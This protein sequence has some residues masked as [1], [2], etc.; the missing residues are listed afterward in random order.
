[1]IANMV[2][3]Q[4][5]FENKR[6]LATG[7]AL[8]GLSI[9]QLAVAPYLNTLINAYRLNGALLLHGAITLNG[10]GLSMLLRP[11][12]FASPSTETNSRT[13]YCGRLYH[14]CNTLLQ[15]DL[16]CNLDFMLY[17]V[18]NFFLSYGSLSYLHH[19]MN[20]CLEKGISKERAILL[21]MC[22]GIFSLVSR[23][24]VSYISDLKCVN[25]L[26]EYSI[27]S[28]VSGIAVALTFLA[29][30]FGTMLVIAGVVVGTCSGESNF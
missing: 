15:Y 26:L 23:I 29:N 9:G 2:I 24:V 16:L 25:R 28:I 13:S 6:S 27:F 21:L 22:L 30:S 5:Y 10:I 17:C 3:V 18:G 8:C 11:L 4:Q 1:M 14:I 7:L 19:L 12:Y 20:S